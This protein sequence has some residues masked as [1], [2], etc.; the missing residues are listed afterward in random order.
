MNII[1]L[2]SKK[3]NGIK[4][5]ENKIIIEKNKDLCYYN[6]VDL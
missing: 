5:I 2:K 4:N 6:I 1:I 3:E